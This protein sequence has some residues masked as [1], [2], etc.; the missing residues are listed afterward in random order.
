MKDTLFKAEWRA[1][2]RNKKLLVPL[3]AI[4]FIPVLYSGMFL[5]A[6]WDP[7]ARL[8]ELPVAIVNGDQG[9][10]YE[11]E[12]LQLGE[13]LVK[14]LKENKQ[15]DFQF[16]SKDKGYK[17]IR[18]Q[19][20]Y[21]LIEIPEDFSEN[22]TTLL[23]DEPKKLELKYVPNE[24][25][26]FLSAQIGDTAVKEIK[27]AVSK[28]VTS[29][30]AESMFDKVQEMADGFG[31]ATEGA[32][33]LTDGAGK[34]SA[35]S[36]KLKE[37]LDMLASKS[38]EF[39][40]GLTKAQSGSG[41]LESGT[42]ELAKGM[43]QLSKGHEKLLEGAEAAKQGSGE[44]D[45]GAKQLQSG[46]NEAE[47]AMSSI[48]SG[49]SQIQAGADVLAA[50]LS[51]F[52]SGADRVDQGAVNL[53]AGI[54]K[55]KQ[56]MDQIDSQIAALP[57]S[58]DVKAQLAN[59]LKTQLSEGIAQL[60]GG[61]AQVAAGTRELKSSAGQLQQGAGSLSS[62]LGELNNGQRKL[63]DGLTALAE[64]SVQLAEGSGKL[65][66]GQNDLL[67]GI[68]VF[69]QKLNAAR[70][71][72]AEIHH[73]AASLNGGMS[74]LAEGAG[75]ISEGSSQ[76][77]EGSSELVKGT[78]DLKNG[79]AELKEKLGDAADKAGSV[80]ADDKTY[81][82]MGEPVEVDK[83][84]IDKVDNYGTGFAPYFLSLGLFVGALLMSIVFP[85]REPAGVPR[86]GFSWFIGK[87]GVVA[88]IAIIQSLLA[89]AIMLFGLKM[90][91]AS[92]PLFILSTIITSLCFM[93]IV[94]FL[95][96]LL[97]DP[98]RFVAILILILQLTTSAG[99]FPLELIPH[100]LQ[101][102][103]AFLPMTYSVKAYKAVISSGDIAFMRVNLWILA[104]Y[105]SVF[106]AMTWIF[107]RYKFKS[108]RK[109]A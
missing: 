79:S 28:E 106:M 61:S 33:R 57:L 99:T 63:N 78:E 96:T 60:E 22:A 17:G 29:T 89:V 44:L 43:E 58:D 59:Q 36:E 64:G 85:L 65:Y 56:Q 14:K 94:Q 100:Q 26:N 84:A 40:N 12:N 88:I 51:E 13:E 24:G 74:Q 73:G 83:K 47:G 75:K 42:A 86:S 15:F 101:A 49:T 66:A 35:G 20:Y 3:I 2:F 8:Q 69:S 45:S 11:G 108:L 52:Q 4:L 7:Y 27:A 92:V 76:L 91:V 87:F 55:M 109:E 23:D 54:L 41:E 81:S 46:L 21:M 39:N 10:R 6:F 71:G 9:A 98:G 93:A 48:L 1:I 95:V 30:Y 5:W 102:F 34:L 107:F 97:G 77:A 37:N 70:A 32:S 105:I 72:A 82:M 103:N 67:E 53:H 16:V 104:G 80:H 68:T 62:K 31:Q 50:K 19:Q 38:I 18:Q 25:Y 90:E